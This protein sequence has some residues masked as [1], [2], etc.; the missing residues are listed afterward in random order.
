VA[1]DLFFLKKQN[2]LPTPLIHQQSVS[3]IPFEVFCMLIL[4]D[5]A[6]LAVPLRD[7][8]GMGFVSTYC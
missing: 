3:R 6:A 1:N 2:Y 8:N 5:D 7:G 4:V